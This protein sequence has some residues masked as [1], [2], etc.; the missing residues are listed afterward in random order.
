MDWLLT[1]FN[2]KWPITFVV[3]ADGPA[4]KLC[5]KAEEQVSDKRETG[6]GWTVADVKTARGSGRRKDRG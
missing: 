4:T 2:R 3:F 6:E 1:R 5:S